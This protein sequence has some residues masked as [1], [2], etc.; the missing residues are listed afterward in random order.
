MTTACIADLNVGD[1]VYLPIDA[2]GARQG[3]VTVDWVREGSDG[4]LCVGWHAGGEDHV[5]C[6]PL[7]L[8]ALGAI[9]CRADAVVRR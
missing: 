4:T 9:W 5:W 3:P 6:L 2:A 7:H 1:V 8:A